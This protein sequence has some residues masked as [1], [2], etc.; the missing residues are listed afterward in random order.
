MER[1]AMR[2]DLPSITPS[3][4]PWNLQDNLGMKAATAIL[5]RSLDKGLYEDTV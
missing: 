2:L 5:D 4:V 3:L 1:M